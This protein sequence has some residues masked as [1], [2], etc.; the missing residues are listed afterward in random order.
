MPTA[1]LLDFVDQLDTTNKIGISSPYPWPNRKD[2]PANDFERK[3]WTDLTQNPDAV[4]TNY[5]E[6]DGRK[7]IRVAVADRMEQSCVACHNSH[8][9]SPKK[10]WKVGDLRGVETVP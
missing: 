1:F 10:D 5:T 4:I 2:R 7:F 8:P 6:R 9:D 3:A